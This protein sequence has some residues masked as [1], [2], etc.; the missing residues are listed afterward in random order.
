MDG[1]LSSRW[2]ER[3]KALKETVHYQFKELAPSNS[4]EISLVSVKTV[5]VG[6]RE[7]VNIRSSKEGD[8]A[9]DLGGTSLE[10]GERGIWYLSG[11]GEDSGSDEGE[12]VVSDGKRCQYS[13][14]DRCEISETYP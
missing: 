13:P 1:M 7:S 12:S 8:Q 9:V 6:D 14:W 3:I 2:T 4:V 10:G 5:G 11:D